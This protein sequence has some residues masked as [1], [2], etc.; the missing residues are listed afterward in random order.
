MTRK[1]AL[2]VGGTGITGPFVV[3]GLLRRGYE[4]TILHSGLHEIDF[5]EPVEHLHGDAHFPETLQALLG[6]RRF[7]VTVSMYGRLRHVAETMRGRTE[8]FLSTG[9]VFY[10]GWVRRKMGDDPVMYAD[11]QIPTREDHALA[12][13]SPSA[14]VSKGI[15]AESLVIRL[16]EQGHFAGSMF[17]VPRMY[18]PRAPA[19]VEWSIVRRL[20]EGRR[21]I[22]VPDGG[23]V[24]E[25]R[26]YAQNV[27]HM[28]LLALEHPREAASQVFNTGDERATTLREWALAIAAAMGVHD[29]EL[30]SAP[31]ESAF[32]AFPYARDPFVAGHRVLDLDKARRLLGYSDAVPFEQ[33]IAQ[34]T[35]WYMHNQPEPGGE[36]ERQL[37]DTFDYAAEDRL[38]EH[39]ER[40]KADAAA[41]PHQPFS[42]GHPYR[43]PVAP[44]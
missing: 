9:A 24:A 29:L 31:Y 18:G 25:T 41:I 3:N 8:Q 43:H 21:R 6:T 15:E 23:M 44:T 36:A 12:R 19:G 34:T 2:V 28:M 32:P 37:G 4:V 13:N 35:Q 27:A 38:L 26:A 1:T 14:L 5:D 42:Y 16:S 40:F 7:D 22:I 10:Q 17:R 11:L 20:L 39:L 30:V 33:A